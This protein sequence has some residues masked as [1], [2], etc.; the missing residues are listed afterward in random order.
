MG[1][2]S[3]RLG[4]NLL[5]VTGNNKLLMMHV[6]ILKYENFSI[7]IFSTEEHIDWNQIIDEF[8]GEVVTNG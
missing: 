1:E 2:V 3:P 7:T 8:I 4:F 5:V 6:H